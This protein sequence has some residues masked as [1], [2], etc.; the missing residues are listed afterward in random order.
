M[1]N[2]ISSASAWLIFHYF[3][4]LL[5][6]RQS[7]IIQSITSQRLNSWKQEKGLD[8]WKHL[9]SF[10]SQREVTAVCEGNIKMVCCKNNNSTNQNEL[11]IKES[12]LFYFIAQ[13]SEYFKLIFKV[14]KYLHICL[15]VLYIPFL[16]KFFFEQI[17]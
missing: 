12:I 13:S 8:R 17:I 15:L 7:V 14:Y 6:V 16:R 5:F 1:R 3:I 9:K 11:P 2:L 4:Y 10:Q